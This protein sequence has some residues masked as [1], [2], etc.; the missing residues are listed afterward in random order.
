[1]FAVTAKTDTGRVRSHNE[2]S[3]AIDL[4]SGV[5]AVADGMGGYRA[6]EVASAIALTCVIRGI[7]RAK[8]MDMQFVSVEDN[9]HTSQLR[10]VIEQANRAVFSAACEETQWSGMG[11]TLVAMMLDD[12]RATVAN[13]GDS[14]AYRLRDGQLQQL[15][16][17]H[18]VRQE[19]IDR[20]YYSPEE[21]RKAVNGNL[22]TRALGLSV[23]V[24]VDVTEHDVQ[25]GDRFLLCSDGLSDMVNDHT[26][27][28]CLSMVDPGLEQV[29]QD[30]V[31]SA[32]KAG[33][34]DNISV[35]LVDVPM[36]KRPQHWIKSFF[37]PSGLLQGR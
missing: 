35:V 19:M 26:I 3:T 20:C 5:V 34:D 6:G 11:T 2:D 8:R 27:D 37:R 4:N 14:R 17:D 16:C 15:T 33:G 23:D 30:L 12:D 1:M 13:V 31:D 29:A 28:H 9:T 24:H 32:L 18:T 22:I 36:R 25:P 21:A 10:D 7:R